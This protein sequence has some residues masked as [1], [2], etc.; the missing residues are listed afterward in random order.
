MVDETRSLGGE[1][2]TGEKRPEQMERGYYYEPTVVASVPKDSPLY[3]EEIIG[4]VLTIGSFDD[5]D[6]VIAEANDT[7]YGLSA[8]VETNDLKTAMRCSGQLEFGMVGINEWLPHSPEAPFPGWKQSGL[9]CKS[10]PEGLEENLEWKTVT[11]GN[12]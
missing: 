1:F 7:S 10:G 11:Y 12:L 4:S 3:R 9:G 5:V 2:V 8:Y 6:A